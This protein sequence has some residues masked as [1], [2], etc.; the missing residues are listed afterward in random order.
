MALDFRKWVKGILIQNESDKSKEV[1]LTVDNSAATST[2]T[3]LVAKQTANR[4]L[5]LPNTSG[6]LVEKDF[7][8]T[9]TNK[10]IDGDDNTVQDLALTSLKTVIGDADKFVSRDASGIVV[11]TK[12]VPVGTVIGTT[13]TQ[14]LTNKSIDADSNTITN[15][16][17]ADIKAAANI[18]L[19]K[20]AAVTASRAIESDASGNLVAST[21]TSTELQSLAGITGTVVSTTGTQTLTNKTIDADL[22]TITNIENADIK[23]GANI[24]LNKLAATT[25]S[26]ALVS[27]ASGVITPATTTSTEIGFVNGVTSA[28]QTQLNA[29]QASGNYITSLTGDATASG[30]GAA[31]VTLANTAVTPGSYTAADITVDS[32][33]R[34][35]SAANGSGG[36]TTLTTD[37][38]LLT[39]SGGTNIRLGIGSTGSVLKVSSALPSWLA[40]GTSGT[41]LVSTGSDTTYGY[42]AQLSTASGSAPSYAARAFV[43]FNLTGGI[44]NSGNVTSVTDVSTSIKNINF[45]TAMPT[46]SYCPILT[47]RQSTGAT[48]AAS[49][50]FTA[51]SSTSTLV[52]FNVNEGTNVSGWAVTVVV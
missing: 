4:S 29:K 10:T 45:T 9:L 16:D 34:I 27:D 5:D 11:S 37:G 17:N 15:I 48:Y 33:G 18:A 43:L 13:D 14:T 39:R 21:V 6:T 30:P 36:L 7:V 49:L 23:A 2:N 3:T 31:S 46:V 41:A 40:P 28:I 47:I 52:M 35:T 8:Q 38:D 1:R 12:A 42:P 22:N 51:A 24:A 44:E 19:T 50:T 26:R 32:K 25:V 20:L